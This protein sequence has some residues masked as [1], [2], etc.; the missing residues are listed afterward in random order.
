MSEPDSEDLDYALSRARVW[1][2]QLRH[3][4]VDL[5][6][7]AHLKVVHEAQ[8]LSEDPSLEEWADVMIALQ[9]VALRHAWTAD[10]QALA[11]LSKVAIN[12]S[13]TWKQQPD[14]TWQHVGRE[15]HV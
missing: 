15:A 5:V 12:A 7:N 10:E 2:G 8:E 3:S 4:G 6:Q 13:R 11:V 1:L 14:G 9:G